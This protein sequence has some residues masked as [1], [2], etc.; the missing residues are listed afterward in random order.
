MPD[1][2]PD[3]TRAPRPCNHCDSGARA[4]GDHDAQIREAMTLA[5]LAEI[6]V[7]HDAGRADLDAFTSTQIARHRK[8]AGDEAMRRF[9]GA[10]VDLC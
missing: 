9:T 2:I 4:D 3:Q 8:A 1:P 5:I 7:S 6:W 10:R